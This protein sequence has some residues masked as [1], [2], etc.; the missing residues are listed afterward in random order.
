MSGSPKV[1]SPTVTIGKGWGR[2][3]LS[4]FIYSTKEFFIL[5][6][7]LHCNLQALSKGI[8]KVC[9]CTRYIFTSNRRIYFPRDLYMD[10]SALEIFFKTGHRFQFFPQQYIEVPAPSV[11]MDISVDKRSP[12]P[13]PPR[14]GG[15]R[16]IT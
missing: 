15:Y 10:T 7:P 3:P 13:Q 14:V 5:A 8:S 6:V 11:P 4:F 9:C 12:P 1:M 16:K 2:K